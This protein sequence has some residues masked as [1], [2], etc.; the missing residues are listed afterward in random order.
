MQ[1]GVPMPSWQQKAT[2]A[3]PLAR[4]SAP[5]RVVW[6]P[7]CT[8]TACMGTGRAPLPPH[9]VNHGAASGRPEAVADDVRNG[10]VR[11]TDSTEETGE[12]GGASRGGTG[13]GKRR[14]EAVGPRGMR[15]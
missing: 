3:N 4:G 5:P 15:I 14:R 9:G 8:Y 11:L 13:G 6:D 7:A 1:S 10:A 2:G 12:Q